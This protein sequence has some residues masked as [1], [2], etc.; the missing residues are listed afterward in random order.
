MIDLGEYA[1]KTTDEDGNEKWK[2]TDGK[3]Y[4]TRSGAWKW[5]KKISPPEEKV[6]IENKTETKTETETEEKNSFE[7]TTF[8]FSDDDDLNVEVIP[9]MLKKIRPAGPENRKKS[10]KELQAAEETS[11]A[12]LGIGYRSADHLLTKY[13]RAVTRNKEATPITHADAD[14]LWISS[15]TNEGLKHSGVDI[16]SVFSPV[17]VAVVC[18]SYWFGKP[19]VQIQ[20]QSKS[21]PF[22]GMGSM[23]EKLPFIGKRLKARKEA[24]EIRRIQNERD[25]EQIV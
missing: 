4:S 19:I 5:S 23:F 10:K 9:S 17:Q 22:K 25:A 21:N 16:S 3:L 14:Y 11:M 2:A 1:T 7:W 20:T 24:A 13:K 15:V 8:D 6:E 18:N 12:L